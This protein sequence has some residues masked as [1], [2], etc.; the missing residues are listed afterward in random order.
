ML[1][2]INEISANLWIRVTQRS[3]TWYRT[4]GVSTSQRAEKRSRYHY[5]M[6]K[7]IIINR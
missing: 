6:Y 3:D 4:D 1:M 7:G 5:K 2:I